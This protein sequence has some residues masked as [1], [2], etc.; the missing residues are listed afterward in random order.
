MKRV[1][2]DT[3]V[4]IYYFSQDAVRFPKAEQ[5]ITTPKIR[6]VTSTQ[7]LSEFVS[8][9]LRKK[10]CDGYQANQ[11]L[12]EILRVFEVVQFDVSDLR[13]AIQIRDQYKLSYYDSLVIVNALQSNCNILYTED[14]HH[15]TKIEKT[16]KVINPFK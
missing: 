7:V 12:E 13:M 3:N 16:L 5:L 14:L 1:F 2:I 6:L 10:I 11:F 9:L 8:V 15:S 4:L